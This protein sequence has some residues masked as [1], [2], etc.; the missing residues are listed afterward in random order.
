[1]NVHL[2][3]RRYI[4]E[5]AEQIAPMCDGDTDLL[6]DML[7][8]ETDL[9]SIV[10]R[11]HEQIARDEEMLVGIKERKA[12]IAD[13]EKRIKA[14][15]DKMKAQIGGLL[16]IAQLPKLELP[17]VTYSVREGK[18]SLV[19]VDAEAVPSQMLRVSYAPDKTAINE[20]FADATDLPNWLI[21]E[22]AS[23]IVTA[24]KK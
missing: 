24:R 12:S 22:P 8:G 4:E 14:R 11:L 1:M 5:M 18:P 21:R 17:E 6:Q 9:I 15:A 13:R 2:I 23:D 16:R 19:V 3:Q 7:E 10:K 20:A